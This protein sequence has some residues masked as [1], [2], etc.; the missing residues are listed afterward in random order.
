MKKATQKLVV[1]R[2]TIRELR[3]LD[4]AELA[5]AI[6][7]ADTADVCLTAQRESARN[8]PAPAGLAS[9]GTNCPG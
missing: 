9:A 2:E 6:G 3:A 8:C 7:G 4:K 1:R 5:H